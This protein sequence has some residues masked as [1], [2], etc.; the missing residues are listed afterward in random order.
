M[1]LYLSPKA[2]EEVGEREKEKNPIIFSNSRNPSRL[3]LL[4][5]NSIMS[6]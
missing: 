5:K 1:D 2:E 6:E 4:P 3:L